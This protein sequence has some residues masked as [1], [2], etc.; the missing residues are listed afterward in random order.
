MELEEFNVNQTESSFAQ[1]RV[2]DQPAPARPPSGAFA[3]KAR[4]QQ[5]RGGNLLIVAIFA[6]SLIGLYIYSLSR[7]PKKASAQEKLVEALVDSA[8]LTLRALSQKGP[9]NSSAND[10]VKTFY[11]EAE[12]RQVPHDKLAGNPFVFTP[13]KPTEPVRLEPVEV[14]KPKVSDSVQKEVSSALAEVRKLK[15]QSVM[16]GSK[17]TI[18][19]ISNNLLSVGQ[20]INGWTVVSIEPRKVVLTWKDQKHVLELQQ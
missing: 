14:E 12:Q 7:G 16:L 19:V 1:T 5:L 18:A 10:V 4:L 17:S 20:D 6:A 15:L 3:A 2:D 11:Y 9:R 13:L 8:I